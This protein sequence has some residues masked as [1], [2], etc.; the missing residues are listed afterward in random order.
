MFDRPAKP[1][2]MPWIVPYLTVPNVADALSFYEQAFGFER[3]V[4]VPGPTGSLDHAEMVWQTGRIML[5]PESD[6]HTSRAPMTTGVPAPIALYVYTDNVLERY[7]ASLQAGAETIEEPEV[8]FWGDRV[9][10]VADPFG[11]KWT[12]AQNLVAHDPL[13]HTR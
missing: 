6:E 2:D 12:F 3:A 7:E 10:I 4:E 5:G 9:A 13:V 11:Y 1:D 8:K